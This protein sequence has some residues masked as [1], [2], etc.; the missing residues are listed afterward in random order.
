M[1]TI[2]VNEIQNVFINRF[3][4][5]DITVVEQLSLVI[6]QQY[7]VLGRSSNHGFQEL[8]N[9]VFNE[10]VTEFISHFQVFQRYVIHG[11]EFNHL[12]GT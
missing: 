8:D 5:W 4:H 7:D 2:I 10:F 3:D 1:Q 6:S 11:G 12:L 9:L